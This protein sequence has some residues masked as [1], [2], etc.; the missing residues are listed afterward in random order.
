MVRLIAEAATPELGHIGLMSGFSLGPPLK[1]RVDSVKSISMSTGTPIGHPLSSSKRVKLPRPSSSE[2]DK[3]LS[4]SGRRLERQPRMPRMTTVTGE[5]RAWGRWQGTRI[6][7]PAPVRKRERSAL[8]N[9]SLSVLRIYGERA[10]RFDQSA[11]FWESA[12]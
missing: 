3:C 8:I 10:I 9:Q 4:G 6:G 5:N 2:D 12:K 7:A 1:R 11:D